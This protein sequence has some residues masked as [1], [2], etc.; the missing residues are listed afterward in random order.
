MRPITCRLL[1]WMFPWSFN[2]RSTCGKLQEV[3]VV[4]CPRHHHRHHHHHHHHHLLSLHPSLNIT[5]TWIKL[6]CTFFLPLNFTNLYRQMI[7]KQQTVLDIGSLGY[8]FIL[9]IRAYNN[10]LVQLCP[11]KTRQL[12][13]TQSLPI[14]RK[15]MQRD[16]FALLAMLLV[17]HPTWWSVDVGDKKSSE[18]VFFWFPVGLRNNEK[19][20]RTPGN[21]FF[22]T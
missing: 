9:L 3:Q 19:F 6:T 7:Q 13:Q 10:V 1:V 11:W 4:K 12:D 14:R 16:L 15:Q 2:K 20:G 22:P 5:K 8:E 18:C 17:D 21:L